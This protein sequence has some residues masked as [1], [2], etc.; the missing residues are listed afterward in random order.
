MNYF[1]EIKSDSCIIMANR[2]YAM[3]D[4]NGKAIACETKGIFYEMVEGRYDKAGVEYLKAVE[5]AETNHLPYLAEALHSLAIM[6]HT[7][8]SYQKALEY[9]QEAYKFAKK[10]NNTYLQKKCL[11]NLG[12]VNSSLKKYNEAESKFNQALNIKSQ[13]EFDFDIYANL[14]NLNMRKKNFKAAVEYFEK[15]SKPHPDNYDS[16]RNLRFLMDGKVALNDSSG[17]SSILTRALKSYQSDESIREKSLMANSI[18]EYYRKFG[19]YDK[20]LEFKDFYLKLY[21]D[22]KEK[23]RDDIVYEVQAK[24]DLDRKN[25]QLRLLQY[26]KDK[27][28]QQNQ[29]FIVLAAAAIVLAASTGFFLYK[30]RKKNRLLSEQKKILETTLDEKNTLL[31]EVHHRVKNSFQIVSSLLYLQSEDIDNKEAKLAIKEAENRVRSMVL[32]HQKLYNK[33]DVVGIDTHEY[34]TDLVKDIFET[35]RTENIRYALNLQSLVLDVDTVTPLGLILNE[36]IIN[37]F[38]H[39]FTS[40]EKQYILTINF[41]SIGE[42]LN[43]EVIDNGNGFSGEVKDTSFGIKLMKA[44]SKKIKATL[45]YESTPLI[46]TKVTLTVHKFNI[47]Y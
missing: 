6:Y 7:S 32:I 37:A 12:S 8:D 4:A 36:L 14:G 47:L 46:G 41:F 43:L 2:L 28:E 16:E 3:A 9:Y 42:M 18:A 26:E 38:K 35:Y 1:L 15:A 20:A 44:L 29:I 34:F 39:A 5:I 24:F 22:L 19:Y 11:I 23:H 25:D 31:K 40:I 45:L 17:M 10:Y 21:E 33:E 27:K 13:P 30:N